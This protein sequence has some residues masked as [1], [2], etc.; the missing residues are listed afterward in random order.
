[1]FT[2]R[3][4]LSQ[5][6]FLPFIATGKV[7]PRPTDDV[8]VATYGPSE[9]VVLDFD[10]IAARVCVLILM[11]QHIFT[12]KN[13]PPGEQ[14][15]INILHGVAGGAQ[16]DYTQNIKWPDNVVPTLTKKQGAH[17]KLVF[18]TFDGY[19]LTGYGVMNFR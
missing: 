16:L 18:E 12:I 5:L 13:L 19:N 2:R 11:G 15:N 9:P 6:I 8:F 7:E 10:T 17:D 3:S 4:F 1:M 14:V